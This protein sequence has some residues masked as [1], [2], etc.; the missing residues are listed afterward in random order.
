MD[1]QE[2]IERRTFIGETGTNAFDGYAG[3][4]MGQSY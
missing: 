2:H 1:N 4:R 3:L